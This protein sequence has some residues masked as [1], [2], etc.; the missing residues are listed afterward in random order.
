[1][2]FCKTHLF[3]IYFFNDNRIMKRIV[4]TVLLILLLSGNIFADSPGDSWLNFSDEIKLG[5]VI[6]LSHGAFADH[7]FSIRVRSAFESEGIITEEQ[8]QMMKNVMDLFSNTIFE[9]DFQ[10]WVNELDRY[11]YQ[12]SNKENQF[13]I[14][15][16]EIVSS[17]LGLPID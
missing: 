16:W 17:E 9:Y 12:R 1:L 5:I 3:K 10:Y 2:E 7:L 13:S 15:L 4:F 6:G 14:A 11:Y 8:N